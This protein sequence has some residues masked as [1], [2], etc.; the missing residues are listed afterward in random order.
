MYQRT[1]MHQRGWRQIPHY[2]T[3]SKLLGI[4]WVQRLFSSYCHVNSS[5]EEFEASYK[6][7]DEPGPNRS[8]QR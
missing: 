6:R 5:G 1:V 8:Q 3:W 4:V 7:S 2:Q